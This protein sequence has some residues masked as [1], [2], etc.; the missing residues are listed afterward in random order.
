[1][2]VFVDQDGLVRFDEPSRIGSHRRSGGQVIA[3]DHRS[4]H[5][6]GQL[7]EQGA[8]T[9]GAR[10]VEDNH[11]L[12]GEPG[13]RDLPEPSPCQAGQYPAHVPIVSG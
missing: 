8:L 4:S 5:A 11:W 13:F 1:M 12:F 2:L 6:A 10:P 9:H 3:V 7:A